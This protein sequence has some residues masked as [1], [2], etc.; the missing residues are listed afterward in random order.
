MSEEQKLFGAISNTGIDFS[1]Y[2]SIEVKIQ[3]N[4]IECPPQAETFET[5]GLHRSLLENIA[6]MNY[7]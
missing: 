6:R 7:K 4:G 5:M 1:A 3:D 2:N